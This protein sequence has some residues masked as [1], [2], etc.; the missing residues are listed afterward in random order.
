MT[1]RQQ[2]HSVQWPLRAALFLSAASAAAQPVEGA[3]AGPVLSGSVVLAS[4]Y[5]FRGISQTDIGP[6]IQPALQLDM[7]SGLFAG[8]WGSNIADFNGATTEI[9][10][11]AGWSGVV[12][13]VDTSVGVLGYLYPGGSGTDVAELFGT[14]SL[15]V[16]PVVAS[17]GLNW[18]PEQANSGASRYAYA[19]LSAALPGTPLTLSGSIGNERGGFVSDDTGRTTAKW[20]WMLGASASFSSLTLGV[21]YL[22]TDLPTRDAGGSRANRTG[23]DGVVL[24]LS[25]AF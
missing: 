9:D 15:P 24:T 13:G 3:D 1:Q 18:A 12:A 5:R 7:P 6:A 21:A 11:S 23:R 10:L 25:A 20:D 8:F 4:D 19:A 16:G 14:V 17:L 22:G 2:R